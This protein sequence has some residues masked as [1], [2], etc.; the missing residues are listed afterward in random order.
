M[1]PA[2]IC[3]CTCGEK[4]HLLRVYKPNDVPVNLFKG[5]LIAGACE[6]SHLCT[7][8]VQAVTR[9]TEYENRCLERIKEILDQRI[10]S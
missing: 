10:V 8:E 7:F 5:Q 1:N 2:A 6:C 9:S 3:R 4:H